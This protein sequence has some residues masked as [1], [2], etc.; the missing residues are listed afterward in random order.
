MFVAQTAEQRKLRTWLEAHYQPDEIQLV[1][2]ITNNAVRIVSR[3]YTSALVVYQQDG[4]IRLI[5][6]DEEPC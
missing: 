2:V 5:G 4:T 3:D 6:S 1:E